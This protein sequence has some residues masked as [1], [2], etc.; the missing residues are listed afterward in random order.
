MNGQGQVTYFESAGLNQRMRLAQEA[1]LSHAARS[2]SDDNTA[3]GMA[4]NQEDSMYISPTAEMLASEPDEPQPNAAEFDNEDEVKQPYQTFEGDNSVSCDAA[5]LRDIAQQLHAH[6][7][8]QESLDN[9]SPSESHTDHSFSHMAAPREAVPTSPERR[10]PPYDDD[11]LCGL[12]KVDLGLDRSGSGKAWDFT[13]KKPSMKSPS[14]LFQP[15][16][17]FVGT[18]QSD[19][20]TYNV[21]VTIL[22]VDMDQCSLSGYL[23]IRGLT[24]EHPKLQT[25]FTGEIVGGPNQKY[26][27]KTMDPAWGASDKVDLQHW[28]RFPPWRHLTSHAKRDMNFEYPFNNEPW[29]SQEHIY[30]RWKEHF[31]VPDHKQS[32]IIGASFEGFY[33]ICLN[34]VEGKVSGVYFHSKSE[35]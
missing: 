8:I 20:Q 11:L 33:Y 13:D 26:S 32:N 21:E 35:K 17:K 2:T 28:L 14:S 3:A 22:T 19:R 4:L 10:T 5:I 6:S 1:I 18:Q 24:P 15:Y 23:L 12:A 31:L 16:S 25:F 34:Q 30:M 29:W 27:F 9:G 7:D